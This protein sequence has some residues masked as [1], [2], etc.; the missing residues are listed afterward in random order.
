MSDQGIQLMHGDCL[1]LM[2]LIP[3][4]S[5]DMILADL[6]YSTTNLH[7]DT[8]IP[9]APLWEAYERVIKPGGA[10]VLFGSQ[11]FTSALVMSNL[12]WFKYEGIWVKSQGTNPMLAKKQL[13]KVH[14]NI[15]VFGTPGKQGAYNP[16][17]ETGKPFAGFSSATGATIGEVYGRGRSR[18]AKN[19]GT[20]YPTSIRHHARQCGL[21]PTQKPIPLFEFLIKTYSNEGDLILDNCMGS[22]TTAV[23]CI[24]S[25]RQFIGIEKDAAYFR[26]CQE[27]VRDTQRNLFFQAAPEATI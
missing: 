17:M 20:R 12:E 27:R 24:Q 6:P 23:A 26:I 9:F 3:D 14:E 4:G 25:G 13:M 1:D 22:G 16:Q 10:I 5:V 7:W 8:L 21:H 19:L 15:L 18:H 11:P 2:T